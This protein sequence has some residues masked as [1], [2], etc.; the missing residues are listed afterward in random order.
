MPEKKNK[1]INTLRKQ[2]VQDLR[3]KYFLS[4]DVENDINTGNFICA[5]LYGK[6]KSKK[7]D[8]ILTVEEYFTDIEKFQEAI[9]FYG[10][11]PNLFFTTYNLNYDEAFIREITN[12]SGTMRTS[13]RVIKL[14]VLSGGVVFDIQNITGIEYSLENWIEWLDMEKKYGVKKVSLENL[15][16]RVMND[17][18]ATW[19]LSDF[20]QNYFINTWNSR[21]KFT[22]GSCALEIFKNSYLPF[23][24]NREICKCKNMQY[25]KC[26]NLRCWEDKDKCEKYE[27][28]NG[29]C[30]HEINKDCNKLDCYYMNIENECINYRENED[31]NG[32]IQLERKS[33]RGGRNEIFKRGWLDVL[34]YD[35]KSMYVSIMR[36]E[37]IPIP[38]KYNYV[39][40]PDERW[41]EYFEKYL[42]IYDVTVYVPMMKLAPLPVRAKVD[43]VFKV[44]Y[45][46]GTFRGVW[47]NKEL[48]EAEKYG[49]KILTVHEFVY[50][51]KSMK[52]FKEYALDICEKRT[53]HSN[54][55]YQ[56]LKGY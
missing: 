16:N 22:V 53:L 36:D 56:K 33:F 55:C 27:N 47:T 54:K 13:D 29:L 37:E 7:S 42:G 20:I 12:D 43:G 32:L 30:I 14:E 10:K 51:Y 41:R 8:N 1:V 46:T 52:L 49:V 40:N 17:T 31:F 44:I 45:P 6:Y 48:K 21:L 2:L 35:V 38:D 50:Y 26:N 4:F 3:P 18:K 9:L 5:G 28:I 24:I 25:K 11:V 39:K 15:Y 34:S 23:T 19:I